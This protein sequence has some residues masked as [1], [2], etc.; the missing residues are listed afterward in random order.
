M[1][2]WTVDVNARSEPKSGLGNMDFRPFRVTS[3]AEALLAKLV[4]SQRGTKKATV[5]HERKGSPRR[6]AVTAVPLNHWS[7]A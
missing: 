1:N 4:A 7:N 5:L 2:G 3:C 6:L